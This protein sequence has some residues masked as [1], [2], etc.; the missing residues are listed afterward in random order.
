[1]PLFL[2]QDE[3]L[4]AHETQIAQFGGSSGIRDL[5]LLESAL[6][7]PQA[8]FGGT[9]LHGDIYEMAA[10]YLFHIVSNHPFVDGNKR[11][12]MVAALTFLDL[13]GY[14]FTEGNG[15][16]LD[17]ALESLVL[18]VACSETSKEGVA[19]FFRKHCSHSP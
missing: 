10:A 1:M 2:T 6:S 17:N 16:E 18:S 7:M 3:V 14:W 12:G 9:Y 19:A 5:G 15:A 13:N 8:A 11:T 4:R